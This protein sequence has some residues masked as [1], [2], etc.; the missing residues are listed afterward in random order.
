M[1]EHD[2]RCCGDHPGEWDT[3]AEP[4]HSFCRPCLDQL[5]QE[6][7]HDTLRGINLS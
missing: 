6:R 2:D 3:L 1:T 5:K 4:G 7:D